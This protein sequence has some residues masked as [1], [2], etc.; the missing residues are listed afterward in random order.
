MGRLWS[1]I[2]NIVTKE[3]SEEFQAN[4]SAQV[5][6]YISSNDDIFFNIDDIDPFS[7]QYYEGFLSGPIIPGRVSFFVSGR[8][9]ELN[10]WMSGQRRFLPSDSAS[11]AG[12]DPSEWLLPASGDNEIVSMNPNTSY[13]GQAKI[14]A[15]LT[16]MIK[17]SYNLL[18]NQSEGR[19][20]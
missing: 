7:Q 18:G 1:G 16:N 13:S 15:Q 20:V 3:G 12:N 17:L 5:G 10:N 14:T 6:D 8:V 4:F 9:T 11:F 19:G 2:V